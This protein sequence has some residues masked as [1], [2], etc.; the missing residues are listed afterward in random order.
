TEFDNNEV[1]FFIGSNLINAGVISSVSVYLTMLRKT[2]ANFRDFKIVY[3][4]HRHENPE[5]LKILKVDFDIEIV[6]FVEPIEIVFSSL[7]LTNKKLVSFYSTA[8]F[9]LNKLVD[10]DVL[11]I[12]IPEK[13]LVDKYLDTTLRVQDYYSVFFKSLAIE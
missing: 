8:L 2:F 5:I 1:I 10:C 7:R 6:S 12:K 9:T 13:Y 4:L 3:L 11:M